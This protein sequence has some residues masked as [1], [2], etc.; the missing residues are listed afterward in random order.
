MVQVKTMGGGAPPSITLTPMDENVFPPLFQTP[1]QVLVHSHSLTED[2]RRRHTQIPSRSTREVHTKLRVDLLPD[3]F[4]LI[5]TPH[6][7]GEQ[8]LEVVGYSID[9]ETHELI[10]RVFSSRLDAHYIPHGSPL[11]VLH[12][13]T[14]LIVDP[15]VGVAIPEYPKTVHS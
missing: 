4:P 9:E 10:I 2:L 8:H 6:S 13:T 5:S 11:A 7:L 14:L 3:I 15:P 1:Y 12:F